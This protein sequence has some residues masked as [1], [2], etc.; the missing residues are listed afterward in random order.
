MEAQFNRLNTATILDIPWDKDILHPIFLS[1]P[2]HEFHLYVL[3][4]FFAV[5]SKSARTS[6]MNFGSLLKYFII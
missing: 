6:L 4:L 5:F 2:T 1:T 3:S